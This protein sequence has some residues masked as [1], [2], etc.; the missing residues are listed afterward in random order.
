MPRSWSSS[1]ALT[2]AMVAA[3]ALAQAPGFRVAYTVRVFARSGGHTRF[4]AAGSVSGPEA[5][6]L[7][8]SVRTDTAVLEGIVGATSDEDTVALTGAFVTRRRAGHSRRGLPIWEEEAY[9]RAVRVPWGRSVRLYPFGPGSEGADAVWLTLVATRAYVGG[10]TSPEESYETADSSV[11]IAV[12]AVLPPRRAQVRMM[13]VR[14][15]STSA[16]EVLDLAVDGPSSRV[17]FVLGRGAA[18]A[19]DVRLARGSAVPTLAD[20]VLDLDVDRVCLRVTDPA[21]AV[22]ASTVCGRL[23]TVAHRLP[24]SARDTLVAVFAWPVAR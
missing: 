2:G 17:R 19:L 15:D 13:L 22:P 11:A 18:R 23:N 10:E 5:T 14:G 6:E 7:R 16:P 9:R 12:E 24:V 4:V 3:T 1:R 20:S 8:L 21:S